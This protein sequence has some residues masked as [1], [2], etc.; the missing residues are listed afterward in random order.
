LGR[1]D[2][3]SSVQSARDYELSTEHCM[4]TGDIKTTHR[5]SDKVGLVERRMQKAASTSEVGC[6]VTT[7][8]LGDD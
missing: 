8:A 1:R 3:I 6:I 2:I 5:D 7:S 4:V